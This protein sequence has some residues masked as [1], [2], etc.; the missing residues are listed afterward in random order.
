[1]DNFDPDK[2]DML[3]K[4]SNHWWKTN[5]SP[6][7]SE[8]DRRDLLTAIFKTE[9]IKVRVG[10]GFSL[11][12]IATPGRSMVGIC[13]ISEQGLA[14]AN[15]IPNPHIVYNRCLGQHHPD[16]CEAIMGYNF[17]SALMTCVAA[18]GNVN[19]LEEA[20]SRY[21]IEDIFQEKFNVLVLPDSSI[22]S[23][24]EALEWL[25]ASQID[26]GE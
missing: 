9:T 11:S 5:G 24:R 12:M 26:E 15:Q 4:S 13:D 8:E 2:L 1:L 20:S 21:M 17:E 18:T 14:E 25:R 23:T 10:A 3:L 16:I 19:L 6:T 7:F 22:V